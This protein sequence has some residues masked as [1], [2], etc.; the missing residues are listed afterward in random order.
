MKKIIFWFVFNFTVCFSIYAG[1]VYAGEDRRI[2]LGGSVTIG[3]NGSSQFCYKWTHPYLEWTSEEANP[4]VSPTVSTTYQVVVTAGDLSFSVTETVFIEVV[5]LVDYSVMNKYCCYNK[6]DEITINDFVLETEPLNLE[7][8][9]KIVSISG[10]PSPSLSVSGII[11]PTCTKNVKFA[12]E[13]CLFGGEFRELELQVVDTTETIEVKIPASSAERYKTVLEIIDAWEE[14]RDF[15]EYK[16]KLYEN[17]VEEENSLDVKTVTYFECCTDEPC[18][19]LPNNKVSVDGMFVFEKTQPFVIASIFPI[20]PFVSAHLSSSFSCDL[21][22][23]SCGE[24]KLGSTITIPANANISVGLSTPVLLKKLLYVG[25]Q[26]TVGPKT[27]TLLKCASNGGCE[28]LVN[29]GVF[30]IKVTVKASFFSFF[31]TSYTIYD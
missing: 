21:L 3:G 19:I 2:C 20:Q 16:L 31:N 1:G 17:E 14:F 25:I 15:A 12:V 18:E 10:C 22:E 23:Q 24:H 28:Y 26:A 7:A 9:L 13:G 29:P 11:S 5:E 30:D 6:E 8:K 4:T 27:I